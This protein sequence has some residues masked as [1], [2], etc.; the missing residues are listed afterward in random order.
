MAA[1]PDQAP[2]QI[3]YAYRDLGETYLKR[4]AYLKAADALAMSVKFSENKDSADL[5]FI[6]A[7]AYEKG[8]AMDRAGEVYQ[9]II[10]LGD[11]FWARLAQEKLRGIQIDNKLESEP[12]LNG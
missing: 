10:D 2:E 1:L 4:K 6:L 3:A 12:S 9:E 11:P 7:E 5:R 8:K